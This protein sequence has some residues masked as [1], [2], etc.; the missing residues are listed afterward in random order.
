MKKAVPIIFLVVVT[1]VSFPASATEVEPM[2]KIIAR[3][4]RNIPAS[5][6]S[7]WRLPVGKFLNSNGN[8]YI[9]LRELAND[10]K[11]LP[12]DDS[13]PTEIERQAMQQFEHYASRAES[14]NTFNPADLASRI[15]ILHAILAGRLAKDQLAQ[16]N[17]AKDHAKQSK[18][19]MINPFKIEMWIKRTA[20]QFDAWNNTDNLLP[21]KLTQYK[22]QAQWIR[23]QKPGSDSIESISQDEFKHLFGVEFAPHVIFSADLP[24]QF[25][26]EAEDRNEETFYRNEHLDKIEKGVSAKL[27]VAKVSDAVGYGVFTE[28]DI[29][30][31]ELIG[32]YAG[33]LCPWSPLEMARD[34]TYVF[35]YDNFSNEYMIDATKIGNLLRFANHSVDNA[36]AKIN[37]ILH[38]GIFHV[39][40]I[41]RRAI[42]VGD[43][44]LFDYGHSYWRDRESHPLELKP[45]SKI[46]IQPPQNRIN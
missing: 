10:L 23:I 30:P 33:L 31:F 2:N 13:L 20:E 26:R 9:A 34:N 4:I 14:E 37:K 19:A 5:L 22:S 45:G 27:Y 17:T 46:E 42:L 15:G 11:T 43:Q 1:A 35:N 41:A 44:I 24:P 32:E 29:H 3:D 21:Q 38:K 16:I 7:S 28:E 39:V 18:F 12:S 25:Y 36:N 8:S 40:L 6:P